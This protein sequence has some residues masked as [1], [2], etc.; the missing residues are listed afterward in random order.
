M[1]GIV[2]TASASARIVIPIVE[3]ARLILRAHGA[4]DYD[5]CVAMWAD[6]LVVRHISG[7]PSTPAQTWMRLL[8]YPGLWGILGFGYWAVE[9]RASGAYIGDVGFADFRREL[10]PSIA[11]I[12]ELGWVIAP[13]A[14]GKGYATEAAGAALAWADANIDAARTVCI[15]DPANLASIR[16][17]EKSGFRE[18]T[19]T[20]Y[21]GEPTVLFERLRAG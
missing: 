8:T 9:E 20:T 4:A 5:A 12:P 17:A 13:Q 16:V 11:G 1:R 15:I 19:K 18:V 6:P 7:V 3:T 10:V 21:K 14:H 2:A